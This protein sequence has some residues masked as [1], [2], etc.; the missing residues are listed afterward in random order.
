MVHEYL[1]S[2]LAS[3]NRQRVIS[4]TAIK[5]CDNI[6]KFDTKDREA[7]KTR[8]KALKKIAKLDA[9]EKEVIKAFEKYISE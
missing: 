6:L 4:Q 8:K 9:L 5:L 3:I 1:K 7:I 2:L